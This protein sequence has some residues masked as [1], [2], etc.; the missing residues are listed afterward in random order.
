MNFTIAGEAL[1]LLLLAL[2][3]VAG[4]LAA[5][6]RR[7]A[8]QLCASEEQYR[9]LFEANSQPMWVYDEETLRFLA[10]NAAAIQTYGYSREEFLDMT[11]LDVRPPE[12]VSKLLEHLQTAPVSLHQG[13]IWRH[14]TKDGRVLLVEIIGRSLVFNGRPAYLIGVT[15]VTDRVEAAEEIKRQR[16]RLQLQA[17]L[18]NHSNDAIIT[19]C[20]DR[21][22]TGWNAGAEKL[23]GWTAA[24][25]VGCSPHQLLRTAPSVSAE[26]ELVLRDK[27]RWEGELLHTRKDGRRVTVDSRQVL[28][29]D[30]AGTVSGF[31]EINRDVTERKQLEE[32]LRQAQKL[33]GVGRLAGGVAHDFNNLMTIVTGY[34]GMALDD[35]PE[36]HALREP[37]Q[38][39]AK[40]ATRATALTRQLLTFSRRQVRSA[41]NFDLNEAVIGMEKLLGR[42]TGEDVE[43]VLA[44][45]PSAMVVHADR[46]HIEQVIMNLVINARDAMPNGGKVIVETSAAA[47]DA[48]FAASH[49]ALRPGSYVKL[50]VTDTGH[51]MSP[52]VLE[53]CFEPF[54]T[55]KEV[56]RGTG[57]GL[58]TVYGIVRQSEGCIYVYS[59]PAVGSSFQIYLPAVAEAAQ[60]TSRPAE[61][62]ELRGCETILLV[63][64]EDAVRKYVKETLERKGYR[65]LATA[66]GRRALEIAGVRD[67]KIDLLLTD[68]VM[69]EMG[70]QELSDAFKIL[71]PATPVLQ[72]SGYADR[73]WQQSSENLLQKPFTPVVLLTRIRELLEN[74]RA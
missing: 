64:D 35:L 40:A 12:E 42:W 23:Y 73:Q 68:M 3:A 57:L 47:V 6:A 16:D 46:G 24:E 17:E 7:R 30:A 22:I 53:H 60:K 1:S 38:E 66:D 59:E 11:L 14:R 33:E 45:H 55:T 28:L 32:Q 69:P 72:M 10:V 9:L 18:I 67:R 21:V 61:N 58:S 4:T 62:T 25:A 27:L 34:A 50:T 26:I 5:A 74:P 56:G 43:L 54:F 52:E 63:E 37:L 19:A 65:V 48:A 20:D 31:L 8:R 71:R 36:G 13:G 41:V 39:I 2:L 49:L 70:G 15:N 51:G 44:L 29:R